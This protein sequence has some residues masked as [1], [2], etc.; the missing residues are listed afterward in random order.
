MLNQD[1]QSPVL[2][3]SSLE[4]VITS[5]QQVKNLTD[6]KINSSSWVHKR[7]EDIGQIVASQIGEAGENSES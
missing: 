6:Q 4:I 7:V 5:R 1:F 2:H 3:V